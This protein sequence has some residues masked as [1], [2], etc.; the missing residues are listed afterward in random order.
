MLDAIIASFTT[1]LFFSKTVHHCIL[2]SS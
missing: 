1:M 2:H